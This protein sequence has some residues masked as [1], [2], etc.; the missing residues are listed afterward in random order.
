[1]CGIHTDTLTADVVISHFG[2]SR[3]EADRFEHIVLG[4]RGVAYLEERVFP[5]AITRLLW[6]GQIRALFTLIPGSLRN[7]HKS[8]ERPIPQSPSNNNSISAVRRYASSAPQ[9]GWNNN[10]KTSSDDIPANSTGE[11]SAANVKHYIGD[12]A[13]SGCIQ[14]LSTSAPAYM[15]RIRRRPS[16]IRRSHNGVYPLPIALATPVEGTIVAERGVGGHTSRGDDKKT[17]H[18]AKCGGILPPPLP[19]F[20][21]N[22]RTWTDTA[23]SIFGWCSTD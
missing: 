4:I 12:T 10:N 6:P 2:A 20:R 3:A 9:L 13:W 23:C 8:S 1:M 5:F 16:S 19:L 7:T 14:P 18:A 17:R 22:R 15:S 21:R 11:E